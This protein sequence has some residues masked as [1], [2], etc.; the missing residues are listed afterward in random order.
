M[1]SEARGYAERLTLQKSRSVLDFFR[2]FAAVPDR[3]TAPAHLPTLWPDVLM[4]VELA[5]TSEDGLWHGDLRDPL[6]LPVLP[7]QVAHRGQLSQASTV[8][9]QH[10]V[11]QGRVYTPG[12]AHLSELCSPLRTH[13][14]GGLLLF[15]FFRLSCLWAV[16]FCFFSFFLFSFFL[17]RLISIFANN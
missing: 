3:K 4:G 6:L 14:H 15:F 1:R 8:G 7:V 11:G 5:Q 10:Q 12:I 2:A 16:L 9:P 17:R 13:S